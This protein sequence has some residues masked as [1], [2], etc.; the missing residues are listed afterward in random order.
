MIS[1]DDIGIVALGSN[2]RGEYDS[3]RA[4]LEAAVAR[5]PISGFGIIKISN[6]W[7]S[8]AWPNSQ[9]PEYLNGVALVETALAP[10]EALAALLDL[11]RAF[12]RR[13]GLANAPRTLDLDLIALGRWVMDEPDLVLPHP[14]AHERLFVM[15]PLAEVAPNWIHPVLGL[16]AEALRESATIGRDSAP[17]RA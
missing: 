1:F 17:W 8:S 3:S 15:A 5:L 12:G 16:S 11:E 9:D 6:W 14:R 2:L 4:L 7:R 10:R 13:R